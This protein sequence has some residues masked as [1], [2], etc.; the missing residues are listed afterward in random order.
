MNGTNGVSSIVQALAWSG[1]AS[2]SGGELFI[3]GLFERA[4]PVAA[5]ALARWNGTH[6]STLD[7][8]N[9]FPRYSEVHALAWDAATASLFIG[10]SFLS[11]G[12]V[13]TYNIVRWDAG[14]A[15]F[16]PLVGQRDTG[17]SGL[18]KSLAVASSAQLFVGG[19]FSQAGGATV[20]GIARWDANSSRFWPLAMNGVPGV[21]SA[22]HIPSV[23]ALAWAEGSG[24]YLGG[25]FDTAGGAPASR[26]AHWDGTSFTPLLAGGANGVDGLVHALQWTGSDLYVGGEISAA[27]G[28]AVNDVVR[29]VPASPSPSPSVS[30][31]GT[32]SRS[33]SPSVSASASVSGS[34]SRTASASS[35]GSHSSSPSSSGTA[36][37]TGS[38]T[39]SGSATPSESATASPTASA[40][41]TVSPT[42]SPTASASPA[43]A[44]P[45]PPSA[46][47]SA[48]A[49]AGASAAASPTASPP[50]GGTSPAA[51][52]L[53]LPTAAPLVVSA[54]L[55]LRVAGLPF[56]A[57]MTA[58]GGVA[59]LR[60]LLLPLRGFLAGALPPFIAA[61]A[62]NHSAAAGAGAGAAPSGSPDAPP[63]A[64]SPSLGPPASGL[65]WTGIALSLVVDAAAAAPVAP[66]QVR[67]AATDP[68]NA[69]LMPTTLSSLAAAGAAAAAGG[70]GARALQGTAGS[71]GGASTDV[72]IAVAAARGYFPAGAAADAATASAVLVA[73]V[74]SLMASPAGGALING[75]LPVLAATCGVPSA[76]VSAAVTGVTPAAALPATSPAPA[77]PSGGSSSGGIIGGIVGA[78]LAAAGVAG[79]GVAIV[80]T[81]RRSSAACR[82]AKLAG[83]DPARHTLGQGSLGMMELPPAKSS[84]SSGGGGGRAGSV[85][86]N[87]L[88]VATA[89]ARSSGAASPAAAAAGAAS[90]PPLSVGGARSSRIQKAGGAFV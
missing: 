4:G 21:G 47:P 19:L 34:G 49:S 65:D 62:A 73:A 37:G 13:L 90:F 52:P 74:G 71:G 51:S 76:A 82:R 43:S 26:I 14:R 18:V 30:A 25:N 28:R 12:G 33:A 46:A 32:A 1:S 83:G 39:L 87:P 17:T 61:A 53:V 11:V 6:F 20:N 2:G 9:S 38:S 3:G 84:S 86:S 16:F 45:A 58:P 80:L 85:V 59:A 79:V 42:T 15:A 56:G 75:A 23:F 66:Q 44:S 7:G 69:D 63:A 29:W 57:L 41:S 88:S 31:S 68:V 36:S 64:A 78:L 5:Q 10:G 48:A 81:R 8:S 22:D 54:S 67:P 40:S 24:L 27:G 35:S 50:A 89:T 55:A 60:P 77:P 72:Y 70:A